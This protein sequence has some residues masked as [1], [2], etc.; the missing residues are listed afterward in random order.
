M[1]NHDGERKDTNKVIDELE[2]DLKDGGRVRQPADGYQRLHSKVVTADVTARKNK[3]ASVF[4][5][6]GSQLFKARINKGGG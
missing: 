6:T 5:L 3:L 4:Q 2:A 1:S